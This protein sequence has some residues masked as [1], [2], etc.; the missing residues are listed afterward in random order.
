MLTRPRSSRGQDLSPS[1]FCRRQA[2]SGR[3]SSPRGERRR[4][5][6]QLMWIPEIARLI[7]SRW[8]SLV[9]SKIV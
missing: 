7:T 1:F 3:A 2:R 9:P 8:I 4:V 5:N 6:D